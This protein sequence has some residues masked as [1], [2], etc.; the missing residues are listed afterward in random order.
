MFL[1][2]GYHNRD[3]R[4]Y[5]G[6]TFP[7]PLGLLKIL[8][9]LPFHQFTQNFSQEH[10]GHFAQEHSMIPKCQSQPRKHSDTGPHTSL[11]TGVG[12]H[13]IIFLVTLPRQAQGYLLSCIFFFSPFPLLNQCDVLAFFLAHCAEIWFT[14]SLFLLLPLIVSFPLFLSLTFPLSI[15]LSHS[16]SF[17]LQTLS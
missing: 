6:V 16:L 3:P 5:S 2:K 7:C 1:L 8:T 11:N 15:P 14:L 9:S 10:C 17:Y 4:Q 13:A 12:N